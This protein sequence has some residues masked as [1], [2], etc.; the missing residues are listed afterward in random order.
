MASNRWTFTI[1]TARST[2]LLKFR[3]EDAVKKLSSLSL[4][5]G[6]GRGPWRFEFNWWAQTR[7][8][9]H[10]GV[11]WHLYERPANSN[12]YRELWGSLLIMRAFWMCVSSYFSAWFLQAIF[13]H[14]R[15]AVW[16]FDI[17]D[18]DMD[19][20]ST[21]RDWVLFPNCHLFVIQCFFVIFSRVWIYRCPGGMCQTSG[22]C[23]LR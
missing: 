8:S 17:G 5:L 12:N 21:V 10:Q 19:D 18:I 4:S 15:I 16:L 6:P 2:I 1:R 20:P 9:W 22:E 23:S 13:S 14:S 3:S 7:R 11:R